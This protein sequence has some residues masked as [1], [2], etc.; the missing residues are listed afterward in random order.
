MSGGMA[1]K[2]GEGVGT[3]RAAGKRSG[4]RPFDGESRGR[5]AYPVANLLATF[6]GQSSE[7]Q[8]ACLSRLIDPC[9]FGVGFD[10]LFVLREPETERALALNGSDGVKAKSSLRDV[11]HNAAVIRIE[12]D[13]DD[14]V[15][16]RPRSLAALRPCNVRCHW[17]QSRLTNELPA[18][19]GFMTSFG[20]WA[21]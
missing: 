17:R 21:S 3:D 18:L 2:D 19:V 6:R 20:S 8:A 10:S 14:A 5:L 7:S 13:I 9:N 12:I 16:R 15:E 4:R 1:L 11:Q